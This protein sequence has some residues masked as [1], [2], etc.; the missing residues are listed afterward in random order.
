MKV[1]A[2][3][4]P[5]SAVVSL[6]ASD[7][8]KLPSAHQ[9]PFSINDK[10]AF[11]NYE[12]NKFESPYSTASVKTFSTDTWV[13][14]EENAYNELHTYAL[15]RSSDIALTAMND[16]IKTPKEDR[17]TRQFLKDFIR[18]SIGSS[19]HIKFMKTTGC[20]SQKIRLS[21]HD[22][23]HLLQY[24]NGIKTKVLS[25]MGGG[26]MNV[27]AAFLITISLGKSTLIAPPL[28]KEFI[29]Q[30]RDHEQSRIENAQ[31]L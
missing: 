14:I 26:G 24:S 15:K 18:A 22:L 4:I 29:M 27:S 6:N 8:P 30:A 11:Y 28:L 21:P 10:L 2:L 20:H 9:Y 25:M 31:I 17:K 19:N 5:L 3:F 1:Y 12:I 16:K 23:A 13:T 7:T